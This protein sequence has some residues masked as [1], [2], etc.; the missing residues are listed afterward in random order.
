[1]IR[2]LFTNNYDMRRAR[3]GWQAGSYPAHHLFGT[4]Y[5]G[6]PFDIRDIP[7][8][9]DDVLWRGTRLLRHRLGDLGLEFR[10]AAQIRRYSIIYGAQ[11]HDLTALA[12]LRNCGIIRVPVV[13]VVHGLRVTFPLGRAP[14]GGF[15][16]AIA[17]C[18]MTGDMLVDAGM[19]RHRVS[20]ISW[21][22]DL[23]FP[24][25]ATAPEPVPD[26]PLVSTGK[27]GRDLETLIEAVRRTGAAA[28]VYG[29]RRVL[30]RN[31]PLPRSV[32]VIPPVPIAE[33]RDVPA[34][35]AHTVEDLRNAAVIAI[36]LR[37]PYPL[38]GITELADAIASARPVIVTRAPYFDL[39][40][41][42]IGCGWWVDEGD[43]DGWTRAIHDA[44]SDRAR[45]AQMGQAGRRWAAEH[46]NARLFADGARQVLLDA[47]RG[48][49]T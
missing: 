49:G 46:W 40:V 19:P 44:F 45:L 20:V 42:A 48:G 13:A 4:A 31:G 12:A 3:A 9:T 33:R 37:R 38:H 24:G 22:P 29:D 1:V 26:A 39:D 11:A 30:A 18:K 47:V 10:A 6:A 32:E 2:I 17:L 25:F 41:E 27:T 8:R 43:V 23:D 28:R 36:P 7:F 14:L 16:Q 35:Y 15:D 21:G 5:F 34:T